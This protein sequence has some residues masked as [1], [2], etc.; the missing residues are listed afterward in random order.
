MT[1]QIF[2]IMR[3]AFMH[4]TDIVFGRKD[5]V[6]NNLLYRWN[7][8]AVNDGRYQIQLVSFDQIN[9]SYDRQ[10]KSEMILAIEVDNTEPEVEIIRPLQGAV[11][12]GSVEVEVSLEDK[13]LTHYVLEYGRIRKE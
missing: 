5:S 8:F 7:T 1:Q 6:E 2:P 13:H 12:S 9:G 10:H 4:D 11:I 3:S